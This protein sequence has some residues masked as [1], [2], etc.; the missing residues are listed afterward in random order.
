MKAILPVAGYGTRLRPHTDKIQKTLLPIAGKATLDHIVEPL[1][2]SGVSEITFIIGHL[3]DQVVSHMKKHTGRFVYIEQKERLG[4]G[5]AVLQGLADKDEPVLVQLGDT[6]FDI[7]LDDM[8]APDRNIIAVGEVDD[9]S[10]FGIVELEGKRITRFHEK[11]K[12]PPSNLAITGLYYFYSQRKL[13]RAIEQLI[14]RDIRTKGEYQITDA[15][16]IMLEQG[17]LFEAY[18]MDEWYDTGVPETYLETNRKLLKPDH[19]EY[20]GTLI[21]E[22]V[23]I[24]KGCTIERSVIGPFVTV[25]DNCTLI[26]CNISDSIILEGAALEGQKFSHRIVAGDGSEYC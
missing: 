13:K 20:P 7:N 6:I 23:H 15:F 22:P 4:L 5:H 17:E 12:N 9:P 16:S 18:L 14:A 11:V 10:R 8:R 21:N 25:M 26:D 2:D 3:G 24:G 19:D 1:L